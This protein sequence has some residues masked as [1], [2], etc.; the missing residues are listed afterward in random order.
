[1]IMV[2]S[3]YLELYHI[4]LIKFNLFF[5]FVLLGVLLI[6]VGFESGFYCEAQADLRPPHH[7]G[8]MDV[9]L[10]QIAHSINEQTQERVK[11]TRGSLSH[12][13][14]ERHKIKPKP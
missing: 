9:C 3:I 1:M 8:F 2:S 13:G 4:L 14:S 5:C 7:L 12:S 10:A 11:G 6:A